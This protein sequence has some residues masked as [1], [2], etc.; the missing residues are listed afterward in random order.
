M[1]MSRRAERGFAI[2]APGLIVLGGLAVLAW[3]LRPPAPEP[4]PTTEELLLRA[5]EQVVLARRTRRNRARLAML[6]PPTLGHEAFVGYLVDTYRYEYTRRLQSFLDAAERDHLQGLAREDVALIREQLATAMFVRELVA[7]SST[8]RYT[9]NNTYVIQN[10]GPVRRRSA[11]QMR[12]GEDYVRLDDLE[13]S[14]EDGGGSADAITRVPEV[15]LTD[16]FSEEASYRLLMWDGRRRETHTFG[17]CD[18]FEMSYVQL[19][20][21]LGI[22][23]DVFLPQSIKRKSHAR[24]RLAL[25]AGE[26]TLWVEVDNTRNGVRLFDE[27]PPGWEVP[28]SH[29]NLAWINEH[30]TA[31]LDIPVGRAARGRLDDRI[32]EEIGLRNEGKPGNSAP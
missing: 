17:D 12:R 6:A 14:F 22:E 21:P 32:Q 26:F 10:H 3:A 25:D 2:V 7:L 16:L 5:D 23:G 27:Q 31:P 19:L 11:I 8:N 18:E 29:Y 1:I 9:L 30:A 20:K 28:R 24:S 4:P 13:R 15:F